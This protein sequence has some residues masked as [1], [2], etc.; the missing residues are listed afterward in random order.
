MTINVLWDDIEVAADN[1]RYF[2]LQPQPHLFFE[3]VHPGELV[4][5]LCCTHGVSV[6]Q[7]DVHD[8]GSLHDQFKKAG[9]T[10]CLV[11]AQGSAAFVGTAGLHFR[12]S[13]THLLQVPGGHAL[14]EAGQIA[15]RNVPM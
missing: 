9:V 1:C 6:R 12:L 11:A 14:L 7:V 5:E 3:A 15:T 2:A 10:V 4:I 8:A 13:P